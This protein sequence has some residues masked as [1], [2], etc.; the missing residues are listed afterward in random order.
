MI[1]TLALAASLIPSYAIALA[2]HYDATLGDI[3]EPRN[4]RFKCEIPPLINPSGDGLPAA[5]DIFS[6]DQALKL[7]VERHSAIVSIPS[8]SYDD[9]GE[10]LEDPRWE[11]FHT[12]H[13]TLESLYPN[14]HRR[15]NLQ[16]V[17]TLGLVYTIEG[18]DLSLKPLMLAAH[19]DVVPVPDDSV[20]SYP[21]F[22]GHFDGR[23]L[24]G[25]G[26]SDDKNSLTALMSALETLLGNQGWAPK[27]TIIFALGFDEE[28]SGRRG[29]GTIGPYLESLYGPNSMA[30][31]LDE[32]GIGLDL[33]GNDTL[34]ALPA[35]MEKGHVDIWIELHVNGG[36]SSAPFPHTGIG[37]MSEIVTRLEAHPWRPKLIEGSPIHQHFICQSEYSPDAAPKITKLVKKGDLRKLAKELVTIDRSTHYRLQTSQAVDYF[38][39]GVK[40]NAMPEYIKIG[41]N[42][43]IAPQ[44]SIPAVKANILKQIRPVV[45]KFSLT[46]KAFEGEEQN[47]DFVANE[48]FDDGILSPMYE[49]E[50]NGTLVLTSTQQTQVTPISPT[51][52]LVWDLF[53]GTIQHSFSFDGGKVVP[54][55]E[56]MT[57][58]TDTRHY[59]NL[60]PNI[61]RWAPVRQ[62]HALNAHTVD[63]R[64]DMESHLEVV[65]FYYDLI[66][67]FDASQAASTD[68][69]DAGEL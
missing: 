22:S 46:V 12:L 58:N 64:I 19:Q 31:I 14:V 45:K 2:E 60:T 33:V 36:H 43:R 5:R 47:P 16:K 3:N 18:T 40:I 44:D 1:I 10:P 29:A 42:H 32:G 34:Y 6:G 15:T 23:W 26:A 27:R 68:V 20:W 52:G 56:L 48:S 7:Q 61:Y 13:S 8:I 30:L 53:S 11:V 37:I 9:N 54:V 25:R 39:G 69:M 57:G 41:V 55:G 65:R 38:L 49:V 50:Y 35:V 51:T 28:S 66:R 63:E 17:N 59:L 4:S 67:N 21:P 62:G 24:W